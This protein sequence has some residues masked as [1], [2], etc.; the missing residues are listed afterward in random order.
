MLRSRVLLT[1]NVIVTFSEEC[2]AKLVVHGV[3]LLYLVVNS[4]LE[5]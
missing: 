1:R 2:I 3:L 4:T 5:R